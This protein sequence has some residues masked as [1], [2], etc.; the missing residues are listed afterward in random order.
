MK[1]VTSN[2]QMMSHLRHHL[3]RDMGMSDLAEWTEQCR[4]CLETFASVEQRKKHEDLQHVF[5]S[6]FTVS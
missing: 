5:L 6:S 2:L 4:Y 3:L 1:Q